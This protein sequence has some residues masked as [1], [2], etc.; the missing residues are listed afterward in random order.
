MI[1]ISRCTALIL[2]PLAL[3]TAGMAS[4]HVGH[5]ASAGG[6]LAGLLHPLTGMD[7][8]L[9][10]LAIGLWSARQSRPLGRAVPG[11]AAL[12][13]LLGAA[14]VWA[15]LSLPGVETGIALTVLLAG[16][17]LASLVRLH[18]GIGATLVVVFLVWHGQ[19]HA[20]EMPAA[21]SMVA[22]LSGFLLTT[23][24]ISQ[25]GR[26]VGQVLLPRLP[27]VDRLVGGLVALV[28]GLLVIA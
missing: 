21:A 17:L 8:L 19:A 9:A 13:M 23:L 20:V 25:L 4:A 1:R 5:E 18:A 10:L 12:G 27:Y 22:Y 28:G 16:V 26:T 7:H 6:I 11:L 15:G 2:A 24:V 14:L 3:M